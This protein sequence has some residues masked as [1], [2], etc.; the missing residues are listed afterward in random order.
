L[1]FIKI[2][3]GTTSKFSYY[4]KKSL[5]LALCR[6][7]QLQLYGYHEDI[8][9]VFMQNINPLPYGRGLRPQIR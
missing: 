1:Q 4:R 8:I 9:N 3:I 2:P 6:F 7:I 5:F